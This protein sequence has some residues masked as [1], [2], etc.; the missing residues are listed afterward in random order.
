ML[1]LSHAHLV[2]EE[3]KS[4]PE[5]KTVTELADA[6]DLTDS[7]VREALDAM[8]DDGTV[9]RVDRDS[10]D[11]DRYELDESKMA[12]IAFVRSHG[13]RIVRRSERPFRC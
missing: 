4:D 2:A 7:R 8:T 6:C 9:Y 12:G 13:K 3:L 1:V 11:V 5:P 10:A